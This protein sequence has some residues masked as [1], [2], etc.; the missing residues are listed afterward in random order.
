MTARAR[1]LVIC[2]A[3]GAIVVAGV[4][5]SLRTPDPAQPDDVPAWTPLPRVVQVEVLNAG[6]AIGAARVATEMLREGRLDVVYYGNADST[7]RRAERNAIVVRRGDT[8]G[9]G[10]AR[11]VLGSAEVIERDDR[12]RLVDLTIILGREFTGRPRTP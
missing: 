11:D 9:V 4:V 5:W 1:T 8:V 6:A 10:R 2:S 7:W 3:I 12:S